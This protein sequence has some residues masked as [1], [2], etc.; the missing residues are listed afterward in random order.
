MLDRWAEALA[1]RGVRE[2][3]GNLYYD[4]A[5][6][7]DVRVH[8]TWSRGFLTDWYAAPVAG[9]NFNDNCIDVTVR[10][11][12]EGQPAKYEVVPAT[13]GIEIINKIVTGGPGKPEISRSPA[14]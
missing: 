12:E 5:A 4:D 11:A 14:A 6:F 9:L 10:P 3:K 8:P 7:D 2:I 13:E 1:A